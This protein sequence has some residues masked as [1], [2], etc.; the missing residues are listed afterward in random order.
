[1]ITTEYS[2]MTSEELI[3]LVAFRDNATPLE[4]ELA[5]RLAAALDQ[6]EDSNDNT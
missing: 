5:Q 4:Q 1:M 6:L 2:W 3:A